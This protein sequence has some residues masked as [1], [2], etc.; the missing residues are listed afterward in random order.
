MLDNRGDKD[1]ASHAVDAMACV[2]YAD[3][4]HV[5]VLVQVAVSPHV[6]PGCPP[7]ARWHMMQSVCHYTCAMRMLGMKH[8][9]MCCMD[10]LHVYV[11]AVGLIQHLGWSGVHVV[12]KSMVGNAMLLMC[13]TGATCMDT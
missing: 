3:A 8:E 1:K 6:L 7:H 11:C 5:H 10:A 2:R 9:R 12:S 4:G 13:L